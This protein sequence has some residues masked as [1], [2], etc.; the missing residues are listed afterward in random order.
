MIALMTLFLTGCNNEETLIDN[1][2]PVEKGKLSFI[3]PFGSSNQVTYAT[4]GRNSEYKLSNIRIYWFGSDDILYKRFSHGDG[5]FAG[6]A[7]ESIDGDNFTAAQNDHETR[8]TISVD[9]YAGVSHFYIVGNVNGSDSINPDMVTSFPLSEVKVSATTRT[10]FEELLSDALDKDG[11]V[12]L[13]G[14]PIPMSISTASNVG[15]CV[16]VT[17]DPD[18]PSQVQTAK[19]KRRVAR[20]DII[21]TADFS[22]FKINRIL[23]SRAQKRGFLQDK[24][25]VDNDAAWLPE[26]LCK[27]EVDTINSPTDDPLA[28]NGPKGSGKINIVTGIDT[29]F[30][31]GGGLDDDTYRYHLTEAAFYLYPTVI[32]DENTKTEILLDGVFNGQTP[33]LY[34]VD[35]TPYAGSIKIEA[36]K[37][38]RIRVRQALIEKKGFTLEVLD[39]EKGDSI[40]SSKIGDNITWGTFTSSRNPQRCDTIDSIATV[41]PRA[42]F[43]YEFSTS[44]T[45]PDTITITTQG[46]NLTSTDGT[47]PADRHTSYIKIV[48]ANDGLPSDAIALA[49]AKVLS[50]TELTYGIVYTTTH[51]IVLPP[52]VAPASAQIEIINITNNMNKKAV[53]IRSNNYNKT[54]YKPVMLTWTDGSTK[55]LLWAPVNLGATSLPATKP[56]LPNPYDV[57]VEPLLGKVY[58]WGRNASFD[59]YGQLVGKI[60]GTGVAMTD[61]ASKSDDNKDKFIKLSA[62]GNWLNTDDKTLWQNS[63]DQPTPEGWRM[64]TAAECSALITAT[65]RAN[66]GSYRRFVTNLSAT[67]G[68]TL[69]GDTLY[70]PVSGF[71][72]Y[73]G[74]DMKQGSPGD[75]WTTTP[76]PTAGKTMSFQVG[77]TDG[78]T[79]FGRAYGFYIRAVR[80]VTP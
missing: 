9:G 59:A 41:S 7:T 49:G 50:H 39:W 63:A 62:E 44:D 24:P 19:L 20:F 65:T 73:N 66:D 4:A 70:V 16:T 57:S 35:L 56:T 32:N 67:N 5:T 17:L 6:G 46:S 60:V 45:N 51:K 72:H 3:L 42:P 37:I 21:N 61:S 79:E 14:T 34:S 11:S 12:K 80:D 43:V 28:F 23:I 25:F 58:Q 47:A 26:N 74:T 40:T 22:N 33:R 27:F 68:G 78:T 15:G 29:V 69:N 1:N 31:S 30:E 38:Y 36:N 10:E 48:P 52:T 77:S 2:V 18:S 75:Y 55:K 53:N 13:L 64:P 76:G 71:R 54:G 8:I